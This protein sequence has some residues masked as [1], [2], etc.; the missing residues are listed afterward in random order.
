MGLY[1]DQKS[2]LDSKPKN[3]MTDLQFLK[4]SDKKYNGSSICTVM[5]YKKVITTLKKESL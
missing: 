1:K 4:Y 3:F 5:K 2:L